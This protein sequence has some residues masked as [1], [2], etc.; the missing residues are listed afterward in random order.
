[1]F[2]FGPFGQKKAA[3]P[4]D[5]SSVLAALGK[6]VV[7]DPPTLNHNLREV[8]QHLAT[9][10]HDRADQALG[11]MIAIHASRMLPTL[12]TVL[13]Q[14]LRESPELRAQLAV[15]KHFSTIA[16]KI[17]IPQRTNAFRAFAR[18]VKE[19]L[20]SQEMIG[21]RVFL[22]SIVAVLAALG[23]HGEEDL[24]QLL[25][26]QCI[27]TTFSA[28]RPDAKRNCAA[29]VAHLVAGTKYCGDF[30]TL[31]ELVRNQTDA[32]AT[33][34]IVDA[35]VPL[36]IEQCKRLCPANP[37]GYVAAT[38]YFRYVEKKLEALLA[39]DASETAT[40]T[41]VINTFTKLK[42]FSPTW[43][44]E[45]EAVLCESTTRI[46][47]EKPIRRVLQCPLISLLRWVGFAKGRKECD[48]SVELLEQFSQ[49]DESLIRAEACS[50]LEAS[51]AQLSDERLLSLTQRSVSRHKA[52]LDER[53]NVTIRGILGFV[54]AVYSRLQK[55]SSTY[56]CDL[57]HHLVR[58]HLDMSNSV[59]NVPV[60]QQQML[61]VIEQ[62]VA[63]A[64][65]E[66]TPYVLLCL[67]SGD[68]KVREKATAVLLHIVR[69]HTIERIQL[70]EP[71]LRGID[72]LEESHSSTTSGTLHTVGPS[73]VCRSRNIG[74][75]LTYFVEQL[76]SVMQVADKESL[77]RAEM[78]S[79]VVAKLCQ[80]IDQGSSQ[81]AHMLSMVSRMVY[82]YLS[83][84]AQLP[85]DTCT[86]LIQALTAAI[87]K[88]DREQLEI[89]FHKS[90]FNLLWNLLHQCCTAIDP[91]A[92]PKLPQDPSLYLSGAGLHSSLSSM[93]SQAAQSAL[94]AGDFQ[95]TNLYMFIEASLGALSALMRW[96][97]ANSVFVAHMR[98]QFRVFLAC[99]DV[100]AASN[101]VTTLAACKSLFV[102]MFF[103]DGDEP[104]NEHA[105]VKLSATIPALQRAKYVA[106]TVSILNRS[107]SS[108]LIVVGDS[109][110]D[111]ISTI[112]RVD[113]AAN[114]TQC[115]LAIDEHFALFKRVIAIAT[116]ASYYNSVS[117]PLVMRHILRTLS[118]IF[119]SPHS[120]QARNCS[121]ANVVETIRG[122]IDDADR[123]LQCGIFAE[124][125][126]ALIDDWHAPATW[127]AD[128]AMEVLLAL[129][130][131]DTE[132][133]VEAIVSAFLGNVDS[134]PLESVLEFFAILPEKHHLFDA[135]AVVDELLSTEHLVGLICASALDES[136]VPRLVST[137]LECEEAQ[138]IEIVSTVV[139]Q[140]DT[141]ALFFRER[142]L[143]NVL[144]SIDASVNH[145]RANLIS[146][147]KYDWALPADWCDR[148]STISCPA[149]RQALTQCSIEGGYLLPPNYA[150]D[151]VVWRTALENF[152]RTTG[153]AADADKA[154]DTTRLATVLAELLPEGGLG[155]A[156]IL[157]M[158]CVDCVPGVDLGELLDGFKKANIP[159][160]AMLEWMKPP[161]PDDGETPAYRPSPF[162]EASMHDAIE[163]FP[164]RGALLSKVPLQQQLSVEEIDLALKYTKQADE[165][166][167]LVST[168][169]DS[170]SNTWAPRSVMLTAA[171]ALI[172]TG[173]TVLSLTLEQ[174]HRLC[175]LLIHVLEESSAVDEV[176]LAVRYSAMLL[177]MLTAPDEQQCWQSVLDGTAAVELVSLQ[178]KVLRLLC[179]CLELTEDA[180][181]SQIAKYVVSIF[182]R[183]SG[184][185]TGI[186]E[187]ILWMVVKSCTTSVWHV[188]QSEELCQSSELCCIRFL[189]K[190]NQTVGMSPL[191]VQELHARYTPLLLSF[192]VPREMD[193]DEQRFAFWL[194]TSLLLHTVISEE[195]HTKPKP[196]MSLVDSLPLYVD[197]PL[198]QMSMP[199]ADAIRTTVDRVLFPRLSRMAIPSSERNWN[200]HVRGHLL[201]V[202]GRQ[203]LS[204]AAAEKMFTSILHMY[205]HVVA[206]VFENVAVYTPE[207]VTDVFFS[208]SSLSAC[209]ASLLKH[210]PA[211]DGTIASNVLQHLY[212][213][214]RKHPAP[215]IASVDSRSS[216]LGF[217]GHFPE[218]SS[219]LDFVDTF[220]VI[221][222]ATIVSSLFVKGNELI[223]GC[224]DVSFILE[225]ML[226]MDAMSHQAALCSVVVL[227]S[228]S[229]R[230]E[231][232]RVAPIFTQ[233]LFRDMD[234]CRQGFLS[235]SFSM[236]QL[237]RSAFSI[238]SAISDDAVVMKVC[239]VVWNA[240]IAR[241][242]GSRRVQYY[243]HFLLQSVVN[244]STVSH[245]Q[246][247]VL[248]ALVTT[249]QKSS[250][251]NEAQDNRSFTDVAAQLWEKF[252]TDQMEESERSFVESVSLA[253]RQTSISFCDPTRSS[254]AHRGVLGSTQA[255]LRLTTVAS[256][257][258][259]STSVEGGAE[260]VD[261]NRV[262]VLDLLGRTEAEPSIAESAHIFAVGKLLAD[263]L[264]P[265]DA[266]FVVLNKFNFSECS[267]NL[268]VA[269]LQA[270]VLRN[271]ESAKGAFTMLL[272][273]L[274]LFIETALRR[275]E[276]ESNC[277]WTTC[278]ALCAI[279]HA[280]EPV[281]ARAV[282]SCLCRLLSGQTLVM[283]SRAIVD[284]LQQKGQAKN[285][286]L[287]LKSIEGSARS[288]PPES[289]SATSTKAVLK[290][291]QKWLD[292]AAI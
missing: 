198:A 153:F 56:T 291:V 26:N 14:R 134:A 111:F 2:S 128:A 211:L 161:T 285:V 98:I 166:V 65:N 59:N 160:S 119:R 63:A 50:A 125:K 178:S 9:P 292:S 237:L 46:L 149:L 201:P 85:I 268:F 164:S 245:T 150:Y 158:M 29:L 104:V 60:V 115:Y 163:C 147:W 76:S 28:T 78:I 156:R 152:P 226:C 265:N 185:S 64:A 278:V 82:D 189:V 80:D 69:T 162:L 191:L 107:L 136:L 279:Y 259:R 214:Y 243:A 206:T 197:F 106:C 217:K 241:G 224:V 129:K 281:A 48:S 81:L 92:T 167:R 130:R 267:L 110:F 242:T 117:G 225:K 38:V 21:D 248:R 45:C 99:L 269:Q 232:S 16:H 112:V 31:I 97:R 62:A 49:S 196:H 151:S 212:Q 58:A 182:L 254:S 252:R 93:I 109:L 103:E 154:P 89:F 79:D 86:K 132:D 273:Q 7:D 179:L 42:T 139:S 34:L 180:S 208:L 143:L 253:V 288:L 229:T 169:I 121:D 84:T 51:A 39:A 218:S 67:A 205:L 266:M 263:I 95:E 240:V 203:N 271:N 187:S 222:C 88:C 239:E 234:V 54:A 228:T 148:I 8:C 286:K 91:I 43:Q 280:V 175:S 216:V 77:T 274:S 159:N 249:A 246:W 1:M 186:N 141:T 210:S 176:T 287:L 289:A 155:Q 96:A 66:T 275:Q 123:K 83:S 6:Q 174:K 272:P 11:S 258:L 102:T 100:L 53:C 37:Q 72:F 194:T 145:A 87:S 75:A 40:V 126:A 122:I 220:S 61:A 142:P 47:R 207:S 13:L 22:R 127:D 221:S 255:L 19:M 170:C 192:G 181:I 57:V 120:Q 277:W 138:L 15:L 172:R 101:P 247:S 5:P 4:T 27:T 124:C 233:R 188:I 133:E 35:S 90:L 25:L 70:F 30:P 52:M 283:M 177:L 33:A 131:A 165:C 236:L 276:L 215:I 238:V 137:A 68:S 284:L 290:I 251:E 55:C 213:W 264:D 157:V 261:R 168:L 199:S 71:T 108:D 270:A 200:I 36:M 17:S 230:K 256:I 250:P 146:S 20:A 113:I 44:C 116:D 231:M 118:W 3:A 140:L 114:D 183:S 105:G 12:W 282:F 10:L 223:P 235:M 244:M 209:N 204:K 202:G 41:I 227:S 24:C 173:I 32:L 260:E 257:I 195:R 135:S 184:L 144:E 73:Y 190:L 18:E 262:Q 171:G 193:A 23:V 94:C 219:C 74:I